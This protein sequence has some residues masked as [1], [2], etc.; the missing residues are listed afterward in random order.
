MRCVHSIENDVV[1]KL[2]S[3]TIHIWRY[4]GECCKGKM[5][6]SEGILFR[7]VCFGC[8]IYFQCVCPL[9]IYIHN[10]FSVCKKKQSYV[11][12]SI[13]KGSVYLNNN[14]KKM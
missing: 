5:I 8:L 7:R 1:V 12:I 13:N 11:F 6:S 3:R 9:R 10:V 4:Q 2:T 14:K